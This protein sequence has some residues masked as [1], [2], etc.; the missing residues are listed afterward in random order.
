MP[1]NKRKKSSKEVAPS[2]ATMTTIDTAGYEKPLFLQE[3]S[4]AYLLEGK[5]VVTLSGQTHDH[6]FSKESKSF[7][8]LG[9]NLYETLKN[10]F[11]MVRVDASSGIDFY[12]KDKQELATL[13]K[14]AK[15]AEAIDK[16]H[17]LGDLK[18]AFKSTMFQPLEALVNLE[19]VLEAV[20]TVRQ[21]QKKSGK[22][23]D[24]PVCVVIEFAD[25]I[26][27]RG[28][29]DGMEQV[30][31]QRVV[32]FLKLIESSWFRESSHLII[33]VSENAGALNSRITNLPS[34]YP[35]QIALPTDI[36][37][38]KFIEWFQTTDKSGIKVEYEK[39]LDKLVVDSAGLTL[40]ALEALLKSAGRSGSPL[41]T[42]AALI[43][44]VNRVVKAQ[45][46]EAVSIELPSHG[47]EDII[48]YEENKKLLAYTFERSET[49][50]T[51][52]SVIIATGPNGAGKS[53][54]FEAYAKA[55]GRVIIRLAN[56]RGKY[57]GETEA[58][59]EKLRMLLRTLGKAL[60]IIDEADTFFG[61]ARGE[62]T[63]EVEKRL[64]GTFIQM[65]S[66][67]D[68]KALY[69]LITSRADLLPPDIKSRA[70][71]QVP[72]FD[73]QAEERKEFVKAM[74]VRAG[75]MLPEEDW[76]QVFL[77]TENYG[78]RDFAN[79]I[80]E[81]KSRGHKSAL[82][83]LKVWRSSSCTIKK[84]RRMQTLIAAMHCSELPLLPKE[85][86]EAIEND[87]TIELEREL[88]QL[89]RELKR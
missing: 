41:I 70:A 31:R 50:K 49:P 34:V 58:Q 39:G 61:D 87:T 40:K 83:T 30:D 8:D 3:L 82:D 20:T 56:L 55:S 25:A 32:K 33:L 35:I 46:G 5:N 21:N 73:L 19:L 47:P 2:P 51:A 84:D 1:A 38:A 64:S 9:Q 24:K 78:A 7:Q 72:V 14:I 75:L 85:F 53:Y 81:V 62:N 42:R 12:T 54:Q 74:F 80:K 67:A 29:F 89:K 27:P 11:T 59:V 4:Q 79:L 17:T 60:I 22:P 48:G 69:L 37:R 65:M 15:E 23:E 71:V 18:E 44:Q 16:V 76:E 77:K 36:E 43:Q 88:E 10:T 45:L 13:S 86:R 68:G 26:L 63:H 6:S 57:F 66:N 52:A 28:D